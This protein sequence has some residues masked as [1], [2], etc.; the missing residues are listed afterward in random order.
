MNL[1]ITCAIQSQCLPGRALVGVRNRSVK[2]C[3]I[4]GRTALTKRQQYNTLRILCKSANKDQKKNVTL[5]KFRAPTKV[6]LFWA[7]IDSVFF[8]CHVLRKQMLLLLLLY[9]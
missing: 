8:E 6:R 9:K 4:L 5:E 7:A 3:P 2:T 1:Q